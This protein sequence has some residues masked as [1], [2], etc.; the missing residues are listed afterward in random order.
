M[1]SQLQKEGLAE[2]IGTFMLIFVGAGA[3]AV[4]GDLIVAAFAHGMILIAIITQFGQISGA[5]VNPTVTVAL[6]VTGHIKALKAGIFIAAQF[7][8]SAV[9]TIGLRLIFADLAIESDTLG[10]TVPAEGLGN[11]SIILIEFILTFFLVS[12]VYHAGVFARW[13]GQTPILL[14]FT[15]VGI[16]MFGGPLTGASL[17]P[18]RTFGPAFF[19]ENTQGLVEVVS[20]FIGIFGGGTA[21]GVVQMMLYAK[22][23]N[24]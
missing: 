17:N 21:A 19:A 5:H 4:T 18:A 1:F 2:F 20:Y 16:I 11:V 6:L 8:G 23:E 9:A 10:Q 7:A 22:N 3:V 14:G 15:L 13:G 24:E 12:T